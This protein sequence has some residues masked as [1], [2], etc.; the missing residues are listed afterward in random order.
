MVKEWL[1]FTVFRTSKVV[2]NPAM[3]DDSP[4]PSA[5]NVPCPTEICTQR[6][7]IALFPKVSIAVKHTKL[8]EISL[9][10][11]V[12][13]KVATTLPWVFVC[14]RVSPEG[15][16]LVATVMKSSRSRS[17]AK[18]VAVNCFEKIAFS[19]SLYKALETRWCWPLQQWSNW[20]M[21]ENLITKWSP[22]GRYLINAITWGTT[23]LTSVA[24]KSFTLGKS[25]VHNLKNPINF[26]PRVR[27]T[28][29]W[30]RVLE[31]E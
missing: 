23:K 19:E 2:G 7:P 14:N 12:H 5:S 20:N 13:L 26:D 21:E 30:F 22:R 25:S 11:G 27:S 9:S 28:T 29:W 4:V 10:P 31:M 1:L 15:I 18:R 24:A 17:V 6:D 3:A 16:A 8:L